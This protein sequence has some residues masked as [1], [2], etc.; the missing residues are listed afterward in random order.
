M[1]TLSEVSLYLFARVAYRDNNVTSRSSQ[2]H[3]KGL[4]NEYKLN[5]VYFWQ[6]DLELTLRLPEHNLVAIHPHGLVSTGVNSG[7]P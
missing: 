5:F 1:V 6:F 2:G 3:L 4:T 7:K